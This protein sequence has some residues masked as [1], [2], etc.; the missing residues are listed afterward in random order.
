MNPLGSP[1][2]FVIDGILSP[3][4]FAGRVKALLP[5][6]AFLRNEKWGFGGG[7]DLLL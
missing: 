5:G 2:R 4:S 7:V 6:G 3:S 1:G